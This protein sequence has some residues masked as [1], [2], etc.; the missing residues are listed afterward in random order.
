MEE[1]GESIWVPGSASTTG[2]EPD[3]YYIVLDSYGG[4][5]V[6]KDSYSYDNSEFVNDLQELG[7]IIPQSFRIIQDRIV[8]YFHVGYAVLEYDR[9]E[10]GACPV[11]VAN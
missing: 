6:L 7:F 4:A 2:I 11:L 8:D 1:R 10:D 9:S 3:I 5:D